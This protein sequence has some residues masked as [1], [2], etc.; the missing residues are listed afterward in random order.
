MQMHT[1]TVETERLA[2]RIMTVALDRMRMDAPLDRPHSPDELAARAGETITPEGLGG[3]D[4]LRLWTDVLA[5]ATMSV[6]HPRY[7]AFIPGAPT[8]AAALFDLVVGASSMYGGSWLES[9]GAVYAENQALRW[10]ADLAGLPPE[11]GGC[12][13]QGGT[14]GNLSALVAARHQA[15]RQAPNGPMRWRVAMTEEAHSS[16][17][18]AVQEVMDV[19]VL[20][21]PADP[22]GR[23]TGAALRT[24]LEEDGGDGVFAVVASAGTTNA[25][26]VDDLEGAAE[27]C[28]E[29]G[30]WFHVDGAYGLAA[31]AA[32]SA[33]HLF[34]GIERADSLIVDPHKWLFAPF[35]SCALLYR[36]PRIARAAH[37][38]HAGYLEAITAAREWNPS[39]YA[40]HLTRRAR[41][42]PFWFSLATHGSDAYREAIEATLTVARAGAD[43]I[44]NRSYVE[45]LVEPDLSVLIFRRIGWEAEDYARWSAELV[46]DGYAFV[47]P[48]SHHGQPCTRMAIVNPRTTVA[49]ISGILATMA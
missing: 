11:A 5:P 21:V 42:L 49:D 47:T 31:L 13:A 38:Q 36:D 3:E 34:A 28:R 24:A 10:I 20:P 41:G 7:L 45:L 9:S 8:E 46:A 48:T 6:D 22:R 2:R 40:V 23:L 43:E 19:D 17:V 25:G 39:D 15:R 12:F 26:V 29:R 30:L 33:R 4:A 27:V 18:Y 1:Y 37:T 35:D 44:R 14:V 16:V 32:P